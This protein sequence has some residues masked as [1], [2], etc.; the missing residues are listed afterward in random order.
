[1]KFLTGKKFKKNFSPTFF[2]VHR[3]SKLLPSKSQLIS[4]FHSLYSHLNFLDSPIVFCHNDLLLGNIIYSQNLNKIS[5]IDFEYAEPNHQAFDI[6]NHFAKIAGAASS[7]IDYKNYPTKNFQIEWLRV[8]L[9]EFGGDLSEENVE[10]LYK[11]VNK[12]ALSGHF[13][14]TCWSIIQAENSTIDFDYVR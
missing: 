1:M 12:F 4:E 11:T 3:I 9:K 7:G 5:F 13:L 2:I 14:W 6:G 8:Y 10:K